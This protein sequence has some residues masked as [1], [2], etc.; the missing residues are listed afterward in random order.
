MPLM[1]A[2]WQQA[3][4]AQRAGSAPASRQNGRS[5]HCSAGTSC[6]KYSPAQM[7][8]RLTHQ[9]TAAA[10]GGWQPAVARRGDGERVRNTSVGSR[11]KRLYWSSSR[12]AS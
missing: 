9:V 10:A 7:S 12:L 8:Q 1:E 11:P 2:A 5:G 6:L 4:S 3:P